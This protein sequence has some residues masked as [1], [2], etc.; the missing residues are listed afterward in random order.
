[1]IER[2]LRVTVSDSDSRLASKLFLVV[3]AEGNGYCV[4]LG[5]GVKVCDSRDSTRPRKSAVAGQRSRG[6]NSGEVGGPKTHEN[7]TRDGGWAEKRL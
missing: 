1:M 7:S 5:L 2:Y 3:R 6:G 4:S